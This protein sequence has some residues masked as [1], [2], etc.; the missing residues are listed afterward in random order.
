MVEATKQEP[1]LDEE[2]IPRLS[3]ISSPVSVNED[4]K[5]VENPHILTVQVH[6]VGQMVPK[7]MKLNKGRFGDSER[8]GEDAKG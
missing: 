4:K 1:Q 5:E 2:E 8:V 6:F 7:G 3:E